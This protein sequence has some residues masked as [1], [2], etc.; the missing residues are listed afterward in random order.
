MN[1][2]LLEIAKVWNAA[3]DAGETPQDAVRAAFPGYTQRTVQRWC[4]GAGE[5]GLLS[6]WHRAWRNGSR[7]Q[8]VADDLGVERH[9]LARAVL[10]H[11]PNGRLHVHDY[12]AS[13]AVVPEDFP[14][15]FGNLIRDARTERDW[16]Q[17]HLAAKVGAAL[18]REVPTLAIS[19]TESGTRP[20]PIAEVAAFTI[21]LNLSIDD[22]IKAQVE[23][24]AEEA[25]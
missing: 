12:D 15:A 14:S 17:K 4:Q 11:V 24:S 9:E 1:D 21:V 25:P 23:S 20:V 16:S 18:G 13:P 7:L 19:R 8:A 6:A 2:R 22:L 10:R 5:A 3:V